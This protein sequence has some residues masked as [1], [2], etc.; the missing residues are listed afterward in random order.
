MVNKPACFIFTDPRD[1][2]RDD[3]HNWLKDM[4][5]KYSI[6]DIKLDRFLMNGRALVLMKVEMFL[7]RVPRGGELLFREFR[8]R[9]EKAMEADRA[10]ARAKI[11]GVVE[12]VPGATKVKAEKD[13]DEWVK[14]RGVS[15]ARDITNEHKSCPAEKPSPLR[16]EKENVKPDPDVVE[17]EQQVVRPEVVEP[18]PEV[19][20]A[21]SSDSSSCDTSSSTKDDKQDTFH[22]VEP[23]RCPNSPPPP[24]PEGEGEPEVER[25]ESPIL[26]V[27]TVDDE[28]TPLEGG[29]PVT[30]VA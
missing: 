26:D 23:N 3:L 22:V 30:C 17:Q 7:H 10:R 6:K 29:T 24:P 27:T 1:W 13:D 4:Q 28:D 21:S 16:G 20:K 18:E 5:N 25:P 19:L 11:L 2:T 12:K 15:P 9:L 14:I 8:T